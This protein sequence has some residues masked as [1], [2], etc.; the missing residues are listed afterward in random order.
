M[1]RNL[2]LPQDRA[3]VFA[4]LQ[5]S[6]DYVW[7]EREEPPAPHL[8]D[9][10]F[11]DAP[12]GLNAADAHHAGL[13]DTNRL[14]ALAEMSFGYPAPDVAYLGLMMVHPDVRGTGAGPCLLR[15]LESVA[16]GRGMRQ[17]ALGVLAANPR[18]R[19]FWEREG[20]TATGLSGSA[21]LGKK[22]QPVQRF[23][24]AL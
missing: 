4:F 19:A 21:T 20:F 1:I 23:V 15:H 3:A 12:P 11:T 7:L 5:A 8:V 6:A 24:K 13:F 18:G 2:T 10:Y 17:M 9:E 22:T 16:L 14:V